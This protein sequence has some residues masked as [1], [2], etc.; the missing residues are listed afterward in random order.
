M[1]P[2][3][4]PDVAGAPTASDHRS[5]GWRPP[6]FRGGHEPD[7]RFT[8]ANERTFL[9]WIRTSLALIASAVAL[10]TF[11]GD[12][13]SAMLR[14]PLVLGILVVAALLAGVAFHRWLVLESAMR[15]SR[16]LPAPRG[17]VL[18]SVVVFA[19]AA[20]LFVAL[21]PAALTR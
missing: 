4:E 20:A 14:A 2:Q 19:G 5:R 18:L 11:V 7:P 8:L 3:S 12:S 6:G 13:V 1:P 15:H 17:A 21:L 10:E 9:A 16:P